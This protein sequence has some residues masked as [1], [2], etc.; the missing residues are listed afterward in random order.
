MLI[1]LHGKFADDYDTDIRIEADTVEEAILAWSTQ[2]GFY[3]DLPYDQRP[4]VRVV[5]FNTIESITEKTEQTE[6]HLVPAMIGGGG[7]WGSIL[8][9]A[10]L[11]AVSF[12]LP[13]SSAFVAP[14]LGAGIGMVLGGVMQFFV[15]APSVSKSNDPEASKYLGLSDNTTAIGTPILIAYGTV[16]VNGQVLAL[17]VDS[18]DMVSGSFPVSP[19]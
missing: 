1:K 19:T 10:A 8:V 17:N 2:V 18:S 16:S 7:K 12:A 15:K 3:A 6:I 14:L 5:G 11:I 13:G 9:G 4:V